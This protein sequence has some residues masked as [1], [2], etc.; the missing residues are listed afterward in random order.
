ML[1]FV[2]ALPL[3]INIFN[4]HIEVGQKLLFKF[5]TLIVDSQVVLH[6]VELT[7]GM[8]QVRHGYTIDGERKNIIHRV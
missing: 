5:K 6:Q 2:E 8:L 4:R 1:G 3:I 7:C